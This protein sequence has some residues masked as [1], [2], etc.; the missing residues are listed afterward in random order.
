MSKA[1][2]PEESFEVKKLKALVRSVNVPPD[3]IEHR[4]ML[5]VAPWVKDGRTVVRF[6]IQVP[7]PFEAL[8][9]PQFDVSAWGLD[10]PVNTYHYAHQIGQW[11][12]A[13]NPFSTK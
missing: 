2:K 12:L 13:K 7:V 10:I 1:Q 9:D 3:T 6:P 4:D 8:Y 5:K 11:I